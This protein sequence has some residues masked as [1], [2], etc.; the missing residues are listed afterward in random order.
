MAHWRPATR[1]LISKILA[2][3]AATSLPGDCR[4]RRGYDS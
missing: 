2:S 3:L 4:K 1:N